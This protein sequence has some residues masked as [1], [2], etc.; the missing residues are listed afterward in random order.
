VL[1]TRALAE[2]LAGTGVVANC[3][4][5]G[6]VATDLMRDRSWWRS[7]WLRPLWNRLFLSADE[8]ARPIV[9]VA[10]DEAF[11]TASGACFAR[12]PRR[13]RGSRGSRDR[14]ARERLWAA[15]LAMI[16]TRASESAEP[17]RQLD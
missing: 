5:P 9:A 1:V 11:A 13:I 3:V 17:R 16:D 4:Y 14:G 10:T 6:L 7:R 12:G 15:T 8:A 2:R